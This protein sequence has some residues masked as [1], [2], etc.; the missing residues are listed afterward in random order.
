MHSEGAPAPLPNLP[1]KWIARAKPA[2]EA[3]GQSVNGLDTRE[4]RVLRQTV[5]VHASRPPL[6]EVTESA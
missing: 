2:L 1:R 4:A 5:G 3:D 6:P